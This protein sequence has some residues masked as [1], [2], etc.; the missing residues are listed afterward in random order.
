MEE[1]PG[2]DPSVA[3]YDQG[4]TEKSNIH[5]PVLLLG[6]RRVGPFRRVINFPSDIDMNHVSVKLEAGLL[7]IRVPKKSSV[8]PKQVQVSVE[9]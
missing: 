4:L 6:E 2:K 7:R 8:H 9:G 5:A 3:K 1:E